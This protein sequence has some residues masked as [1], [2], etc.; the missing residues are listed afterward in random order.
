[1]VDVIKFLDMD[2]ALVYPD[3][4]LFLRS[5]KNFHISKYI[6]KYGNNYEAIKTI[7]KE[8]N[9]IFNFLEK[10]TVDLLTLYKRKYKINSD[11]ITI[12]EG[13]YIKMVY[14][15]K[16]IRKELDN[17]TLH[18]YGPI[19]SGTFIKI[20]AKGEN[21]DLFYA[22]LTETKSLLFDLLNAIFS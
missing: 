10:T 13:K 17:N 14:Y 12:M 6:E 21:E 8:H 22:Y 11:S 16:D 19:L 3:R 18:M 1:M 15:N 9:S 4:S 2:T 20:I 5:L 7:F